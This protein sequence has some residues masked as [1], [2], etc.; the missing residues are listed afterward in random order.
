MRRLSLPQSVVAFALASA[1]LPSP[2][3]AQTGGFPTIIQRQFTGGSAKVTVAG[4]QAELTQKARARVATMGGNVVGDPGVRVALVLSG[5]V[6]QFAGM[7]GALGGTDS[8]TGTLVREGSGPVAPDEDVMYRGLLSRKTQVSACG[9]KP[10][11]TEDQ[12]DVCSATLVG[13]AQ[14][15]VELEVNEGD[16]GAWIKMKAHPNYPITKSISGCPEPGEWL[17][18]YYPDGASGLGIETVP[19]GL[20]R[21]GTYTEPGVSL[22]VIRE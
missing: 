11:P 15:N 12:V 20:L 14:M 4:T 3:T 21:V 17:K 9:T 18:D 1:V 2:T 10:S 7:C 19:S 8:L 13:S 6:G 5:E 16:R 22:E